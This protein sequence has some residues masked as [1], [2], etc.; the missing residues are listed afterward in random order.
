MVQFVKFDVDGA[1]VRQLELFAR[2]IGLHVF[3]SELLV[4]KHPADALFAERVECVV[5]QGQVAVKTEAAGNID[6]GLG[7]L[8]V[9][10]YQYVGFDAGAA[11]NDVA[12]RFQIVVDAFAVRRECFVTA[13]LVVAGED[14][15]KL[16]SAGVALDSVVQVVGVRSDFNQPACLHFAY[17]LPCDEGGTRQCGF[18]A[19]CDT[20]VGRRFQP[21]GNQ[22]INGGVVEGF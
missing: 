11:G 13:V 1:L 22:R 8:P 6:G 7:K 4:G 21:R 18:P 5:V 15:G 20:S 19:V 17:L 10:P 3:Q 9:R 2:E 12:R 16:R 14:G